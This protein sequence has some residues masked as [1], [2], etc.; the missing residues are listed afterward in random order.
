MLSQDHIT[1]QNTIRNGNL[2]DVTPALP[3]INTVLPTSSSSTCSSE[4]DDSLLSPSRRKS[5][6]FSNETAVGIAASEKNEEK[7]KKKDKKNK[8]ENNMASINKN[9]CTNFTSHPYTTH[10]VVKFRKMKMK[11]CKRLP[12]VPKDDLFL[13]QIHDRLKLSATDD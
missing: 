8:K 13:Q 9:G 6:T 3:T 5:V 2:I 11:H 4:E 7:K 12:E 1:I 10:P